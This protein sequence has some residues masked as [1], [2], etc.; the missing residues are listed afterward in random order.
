[1]LEEIKRFLNQCYQ[2]TDQWK[3]DQL[4][5]IHFDDIKLYTPTANG[6]TIIKWNELFAENNMEHHQKE[7]KY[8]LVNSVSK[9]TSLIANFDFSKI[10]SLTNSSSFGQSDHIN[11]SW[12]KDIAEWGYAMYSGSELSN[13]DE[14]D[15]ENNISHIEQQGFT[16]SKPLDISHYKWC[17][18]YECYNSGGSHHAAA[19]SSQMRYQQFQYYRNAEVTEYATNPECINELEQQGFYLFLI[20]GFGS[21]HKISHKKLRCEQIIGDLISDRFYSIPL[22][23]STPNETQIM[24]IRKEDLKIKARIFE[25]WYHAQLKMGNLVRLQE[26]M[27]DTS[28]YC[29]TAYVH[30][31]KWLKLGDPFNTNNLKVKEMKK[32]TSD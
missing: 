27:E 8:A 21:A 31:F 19:A 11:G 26:A 5:Q 23:Y 15:W 18:R 29:T 4:H 16:K 22:H 17:N 10:Q 30:Q 14:H 32:H 9:K 7:V 1:M 13:I 6:N 25:K 12:F 20:A 28:K 24:I 2:Q 3:L